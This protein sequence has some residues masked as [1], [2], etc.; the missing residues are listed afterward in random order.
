VRMGHG[1]IVK[2]ISENN[3]EGRRRIEKPRL[4]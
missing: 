2:E 3:A 1:R 4:R